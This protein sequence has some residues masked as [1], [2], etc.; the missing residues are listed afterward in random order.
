[1]NARYPICVTTPLRKVQRRLGRARLAAA[2]MVP[3]IGPALGLWIIVLDAVAAPPPF[4]S[5]A[6]PHVTSWI[7]NTYPGAKRWVQQDIRAMAVTE[8][9]TVFTNVEWEEGGGNVGE[10]RDGALVRYAM[11]THGWGAGGGVSV[12]VNS[13]YVFI[14]MAM[15]NEGGGLKDDEHVAAER[16]EV[17]RRVAASAQRSSRSRRRSPAAK[18]ARATR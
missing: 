2:L 1:M 14:G 9:G 11:H 5:P 7:G 17:V 6:L 10:Y 8:D 3:V 13:N 16:R 18:E 12:A 15:G 4:T